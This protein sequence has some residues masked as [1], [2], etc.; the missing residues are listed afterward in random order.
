M[1]RHRQDEWRVSA[2]S[3]SRQ[4]LVM[5]RRIV[6]AGAWFIAVGWAFNY[7]ALVVD[8][9][10]L[11]GILLAAVVAIFVAYDPLRVIWPI[12][13]RAPSKAFAAGSQPQSRRPRI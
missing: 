8:V 4:D 2:T 9:P 1:G 10:S 7:V 11:A 3:E 13:E 5:L 6:S 12:N